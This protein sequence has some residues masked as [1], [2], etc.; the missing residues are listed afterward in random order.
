MDDVSSW[1]SVGEDL[2]VDDLTFWEESKGESDTE[3]NVPPEV[4]HDDEASYCG[5][6]SPRITRNDD[7]Y[8][9]PTADVLL[10]SLDGTRFGVHKWFLSRRSDFIRDLLATCTDGDLIDP[11]IY[12]DAPS[13][14]VK[15]FVQWIYSSA[16]SPRGLPIALI[17]DLLRLCDR[18]HSDT[19]Y[20]IIMLSLRTWGSEHM[21]I[22]KVASQLD[23][24]E[25]ARH[26]LRNMPDDNDDLGGL[27]H[28]K[29][30]DIDGI[31]E[32]FLIELRR[33]RSCRLTFPVV[34]YMVNSWKVVAEH[35][36]PGGRTEGIFPPILYGVEQPQFVRF[37]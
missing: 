8:N 26:V 17:A 19:L 3:S 20:D 22:L 14:V 30:T 16:T 31:S 32:S 1:E 2:V 27:F 33:C 37:R 35:F 15:L 10:E 18:F 4:L 21:E 6:A 12:V 5:E 9:D 36:D 7:E 25:L 34:T 11:P 23:D 24:V 28:L 29:P 13:P